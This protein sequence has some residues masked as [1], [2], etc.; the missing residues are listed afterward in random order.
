[1]GERNGK[2]EMCL[3]MSI[4][5]NETPRKANSLKKHCKPQGRWINDCKIFIELNRPAER[6]AKVAANWT[7][8]YDHPISNHDWNMKKT[9]IITRGYVRGQKRQQFSD[10][11]GVSNALGCFSVEIVKEKPEIWCLDGIQRGAKTEE[12]FSS[13]GTSVWTAC[14]EWI[15]I[16]EWPEQQEKLPTVPQSPTYRGQ[17]KRKSKKRHQ[18]L[19]RN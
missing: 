19:T 13:L 11:S 10:M 12:T 4:S 15:L 16:P 1:M 7:S 6:S 5:P 9:Q 2:K 3:S 14:S 17:Y 8:R 18:W